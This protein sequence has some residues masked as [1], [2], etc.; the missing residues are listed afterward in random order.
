M[1]RG[2]DHLRVLARHTDNLDQNRDSYDHSVVHETRPT[3]I[4]RGFI[5]LYERS[6][7]EA[8][9]RWLNERQDDLT[10]Y[11]QGLVRGGLAAVAVRR[12]ATQKE[13]IGQLHNTMEWCINKLSCFQH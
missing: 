12:L 3:V 9:A 5:H 4:G 13:F 1:P 6:G 2:S 7:T 10:P 8:V 11:I